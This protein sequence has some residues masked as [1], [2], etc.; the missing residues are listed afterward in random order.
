MAIM[1]LV[2]FVGMVQHG[3]GL[4]SKDI[5]AEWNE[6]LSFWSYI[7]GPFCT[8]GISLVKISVG[9]FLRRFV[10]KGWQQ[11]FILGMI[12]FVAVF[13]IYSIITFMV[14]CIPVTAIWDGSMGQPGVQCWSPDTLSLIGTVNGGKLRGGLR[15]RRHVF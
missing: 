6:G 3:A 15:L 5:P 2:C 9:L 10:P 11:H 13:M 4:S 14:A 7:I 12:A 1:C 8:T